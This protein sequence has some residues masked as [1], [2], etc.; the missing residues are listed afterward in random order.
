M[1]RG[2]NDKPLECRAG[3]AMSTEAG[4]DVQQELE[5]RIHEFRTSAPPMPVVVVHAEDDAADGAVFALVEELAEVQREH[6]SWCAVVDAEVC[7]EGDDPTARAASLLRDLSGWDGT[8][9]SGRRRSPLYRRYAFP[10]PGLIQAIEDAARSEGGAWPRTDD[11]RQHTEAEET[12]RKLLKQLAKQRWRPA[13]VPGSRTGLRTGFGL[14]FVDMGNVLPASVVA[15]LGALFARSEWY[16]S[17][18]WGLGILLALI[19][20]NHMPGRAPLFLW[21]RRE[22]KWFLTTT[23]L[24]VASREQPTDTSILRPIRSWKAIASRAYDVAGWLLDERE[25]SRIQLYVLAMLE[26]LRDSHTRWS[27]DLRGFKRSRPPLLFLPRISNSNGGIELIRA[28]SDVR[29]RRSELDPLLVLAGVAARDVE[30][31]KPRAGSAAAPGRGPARAEGLSRMRMRY[32]D[33]AGSL[34]STQSPSGESTL[35]WVLTLPLP[36]HELTTLRERDRHCVK[37][38]NRPTVARVVW[39]LHSL[40]L[41]A[42]LAAALMGWRALSLDREHCASGLLTANTYTEKKESGRGDQV[43]CIGLATGGVR[44]SDW[45]S[46]KQDEKRPMSAGA[47]PSSWTVAELEEAVH[48]ENMEVREGSGPFVTVVYAGPLSS[49]PDGAPSPVKG[50]EELAGVHVAQKAINDTS[51]RKLRVLVANGGVDMQHQV[52]MADKIAAYADT[53]PTLIGVVG[54]GRNLRSGKET[55][56]RLAEAGLPVVSG[57][58]SSS[59]L[60]KKLA[61]WFSLAAPDDWQAEQLGLIARQLRTPGSDQSALVLA[62][63]QPDKGKGTGTQKEREGRTDAYTQAQ[64]AF[65]GRMLAREGFTMQDLLAYDVPNGTPQ[66]GEQA[67]TI[68]KRKDVPTV[69]YFAGRVEDLRSLMSEL[70]EEKGCKEDMTIL[71]G[72]D[73]S[74]ARFAPDKERVGP[75]VTLYHVTLAKMSGPG[76]TDFYADAQKA[77]PESFPGT[78]G[79]D[80]PQLAS[81]QAALSHDATKALHTAAG[82]A[83]HNRAATW[84]NLRN[85]SV[86]SLATGTIDF[87]RA[88]LYEARAGHSIALVEVRREEGGDTYRSAEV[89]SRRAGDTARLTEED[90]RIR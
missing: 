11:G 51:S 61:N 35:P 41:V 45:L 43:E 34:R 88:P 57:T 54:I 56:E 27:W 18:G 59:E 24:S 20:L 14:R 62:R 22:S 1:S 63:K 60:P 9:S 83:P 26:D 4:I 39:A 81:G 79:P 90:C 16:A 71:T 36:S 84:V 21:L 65:G 3:H 33:W 68:C 55:V 89:C 72:D 15:G 17:L 48:D 10:R 66:M 64:A 19:L 42:C 13:A 58:N 75:N 30:R 80:S 74:K 78:I 8:R 70:G 5:D 76:D 38:S 49:D 31:L 73:L 32:R 12:Q 85:V 69:I 52:T 28:I 82:K 77:F 87:T 47:E 44:F 6:R 50:I 53:D 46:D 86:K 29:S 25:G 7:G 37:A 23:F 2:Q 67:E 40:V